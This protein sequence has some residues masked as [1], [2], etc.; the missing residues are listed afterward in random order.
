[1]LFFN[2]LVAYNIRK[3]I[4]K[5]VSFSKRYRDK[6]LSRRQGYQAQEIFS[7]EGQDG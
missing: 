6:S 7:L 5:V 4:G 2:S 3:R 1:M